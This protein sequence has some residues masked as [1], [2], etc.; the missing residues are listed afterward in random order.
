MRKGKHDTIWNTSA[1]CRR[2]NIWIVP[3]LVISAAFP[4]C[5]L[6]VQGVAKGVDDETGAG[7]LTVVMREVQ[8]TGGMWAGAWRVDGSFLYY[9]L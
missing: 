1:A 8:R 6:A 5:M 4:T 3:D 7:N 2:L 9:F